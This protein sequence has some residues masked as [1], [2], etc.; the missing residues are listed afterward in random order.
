MTVLDCK[1][2]T[3][4]HSSADVNT[5]FLFRERWFSLHKSHFLYNEVPIKSH[6][7]SYKILIPQAGD[8]FHFKWASLY[9]CTYLSWDL[10][11]TWRTSTLDTLAAC[12]C[13][14]AQMWSMA[15]GVGDE[16]GKW[17]GGSFG[18]V[19]FVPDVHW[20]RRAPKL[21]YGLSKEANKT[22]FLRGMKQR[23]KWKATDYMG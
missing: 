4:K 18:N 2:K 22:I 5:S 3:M 17:G 19:K 23:S 1:Q 13:G 21:E 14:K 12:P 7:S 16:P 11:V 15:Q 9:T 6:K 10:T 20:H 8:W